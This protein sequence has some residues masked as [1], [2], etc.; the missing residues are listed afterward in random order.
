MAT[1]VGYRMGALG[2][3]VVLLVGLFVLAGAGYPAPP[4]SGPNLADPDVSPKNFAGEH[5]ETGG[6]VI[7]TDPVTIEIEDGT[8]TQRLPVKNAP[9]VRVGQGIIV[10]GT[11]TTDGTLVVNRD[12]A[13]V[14]EPWETTYMYAISVLGALFVAV[15]IFDGWRFD[16]N[17]I[18]FSPRDTPLHTRYLSEEDTDG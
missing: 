17:E 4:D 14:R 10:D 9:D 12:R 5:V 1:A 6:E 8:S 15:R 16:L 3:C 7:A 11:L 18:A 2:V 13:V